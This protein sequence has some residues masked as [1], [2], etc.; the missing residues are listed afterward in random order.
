MRQQSPEVADLEAANVELASHD[1]EQEFEVE[2]VEEVDA[3]VT[4]VGVAHRTCEAFELF[5]A[6][7]R[8]VEAGQELEIATVGSAEQVAHDAEAVKGLLDGGELSLAGAVAVFHRAV[9]LEEADIVRHGLDAEHETELFLPL[10][11]TTAHIMAVTATL[12][13]WA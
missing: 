7:A 5:A 12:A 6:G 3:T 11:G 10:E 9:L 13:G 1:G 2:R 8:V 4:A